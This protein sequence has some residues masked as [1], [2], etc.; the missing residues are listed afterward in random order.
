MFFLE[1]VKVGV[2]IQNKNKKVDYPMNHQFIILRK[3]KFQEYY[4]IESHN[5]RKLDTNTITKKE[6]QCFFMQ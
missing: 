3:Y 6:F 2:L 4:F 5:T 1:K